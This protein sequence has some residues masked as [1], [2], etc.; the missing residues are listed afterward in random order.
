MVGKQK[1][2]EKDD[3]SD[4]VFYSYYRGNVS[5]ENSGTTQYSTLTKHSFVF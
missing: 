2:G 4:T 5:N 3:S 1:E